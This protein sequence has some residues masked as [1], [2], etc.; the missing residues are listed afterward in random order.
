VSDAPALTPEKPYEIERGSIPQVD[1]ANFR[2]GV[3]VVFPEGMVERN[4]DILVYY[5][6]ADVS[7]AAAR[8]ARQSLIASLDG[9]IADHAGAL[10][11]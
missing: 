4:G 2:D 8:V 1:P 3:R 5:G 6:A 11:L 10:P 7:V 9:A